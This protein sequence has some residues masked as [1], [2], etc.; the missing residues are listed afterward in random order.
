MIISNPFADLP[1]ASTDLPIASTAQ[2]K[3][4]RKVPDTSQ[5]PT[6]RPVTLRHPPAL[7]C[8]MC[9]AVGP[10][11]RRVTCA[12]CPAASKISSLLRLDVPSRRS[13]LTRLFFSGG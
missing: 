3:L 10:A 12:W 13:F 4:A 9:V 2:G 11:M 7:P 8:R 5:T 6:Q 1:L